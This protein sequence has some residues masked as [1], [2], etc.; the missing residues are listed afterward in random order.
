M[1]SRWSKCHHSCWQDGGTIL[2]WWWWLSQENFFHVQ[3]STLFTFCLTLRKLGENFQIMQ[4]LR[5]SGW[6]ESWTPTHGDTFT[7]LKIMVWAI[8]VPSITSSPSAPN[9]FSC[10]SLPL[11]PLSWSEC[12]KEPS[13]SEFLFHTDILKVCGKMVLTLSKLSLWR[14]RGLPKRRVI[15]GY[16]SFPFFISPLKWLCPLLWLRTQLIC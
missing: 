1:F 5:H 11:P 2:R 6:P 3:V 12:R 13:T 16:L 4:I 14:C 15:W 7:L 9:L 10:S 8:H